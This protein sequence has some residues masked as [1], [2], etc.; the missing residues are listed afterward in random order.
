M[1]YAYDAGTDSG[2]SYTSIDEP[3]DPPVPI[4]KIEGYPFI[5]DQSLIPLGTFVFTKL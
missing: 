5:S 1:L 3:T 2:N 4:F